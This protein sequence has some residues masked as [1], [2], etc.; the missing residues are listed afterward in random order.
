MNFLAKYWRKYWGSFLLAVLFVGLESICDLFQP[1]LMSLLVDEGALAGSL[2]LVGKYG[3][4]MLGVAVLGMCC[5]LLRNYISFRVAMGFS[6]D[7]RLDL[8][9]KIH[10]LSCTKIDDLEEGSLIVRET[11]DV[12]QLQSFASE[13]MRMAVKAPVICIGSIFMVASMS[14]HTVPIIVPVVVAVL[15]VIVLSMKLAYPRFSAL[16]SALDRLNTTVR[17]YLVGIRLVKAFRRLRDEKKRFDGANSNLMDKTIQANRVLLIFT[18]FLTL[19]VNLGIAAILWFGAG[20]VDY[21]EMEVGQVM[22]FVTYMT[23]ILSS[24]TLISN[25]LNSFVRAKASHRRIAEVFQ[26]EPEGTVSGAAQDR[27]EPKPETPFLR[28]EEVSFRYEGSTGQSTLRNISFSL[29]AGEKLGIIGPTGSGKSTLASLLLRFY[30]PS[31]G[32]ILVNGVPLSSLDVKGWRTHVGLV[33]QT[34]V[35]FTG[36]LRENIAW[37]KEGVSEAEMVQAAKDAQAMEFIESFPEGFDHAIGQSGGL[38]GGQKQ[39][40]SIARALVRKPELLVL[41]DCTSALDL[42]TEAMVRQALAGYPMTTIYITQRISTAKACDRIL[43]LENGAMAGFG[44]HEE[45]MAS[46]SLYQD[47]YRSQVGGEDHG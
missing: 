21:G 22:A 8:F 14:L 43:V 45:L 18:P 2:P 24:L 10:S 27:P 7:L 15:F 23:S 39:R 33:P 16:Q 44:T 17:E 9:E 3:L 11:N 1:K 31:E 42:A 5:A 37:G 35:L 13:L 36:T 47:I 25:S 6:A 38:S 12:T 34:P 40:L 32:E 28:F 30:E 29:A 4:M 41:D 46:C 19:I 20:W 26:A